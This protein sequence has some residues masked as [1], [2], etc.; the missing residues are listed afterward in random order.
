M[1]DQTGGYANLLVAVAPGPRHRGD[2]YVVRPGQMAKLQVGRIE[3][4]A[5]G[6][7]VAR[8]RDVAR[9]GVVLAEHPR[10]LCP[11]RDDLA[12]RTVGRCVSDQSMVMFAVDSGMSYLARPQLPAP[13]LSASRYDKI[14]R[15]TRR[16]MAKIVNIGLTPEAAGKSDASAT[17]SPFVP[18]TRPLGS[19]TP[20]SALMC[21]RADPI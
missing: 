18:R 20:C 12:R 10:R 13:I 16:A 14:Y 15:A 7:A 21:I 6:A 2:G 9:Q 11:L 4:D 3:A 8:R 1:L 19:H 5:G 17:H